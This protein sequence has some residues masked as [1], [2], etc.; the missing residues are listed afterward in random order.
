MRFQPAAAWIL[1]MSVALAQGTQGLPYNQELLEKLKDSNAM[2]RREA[3]LDLA[4]MGADAR[5]AVPDLQKAAVEADAGVRGASAYA[6]GEIGAAAEPASTTLLRN[7]TTDK[8]ANVRRECAVALGKIGPKALKT[9]PGLLT[10]LRQDSDG[11]VREAIAN[12]IVRV[13]SQAKEAWAGLAEALADPSPA[14]RDVAAR[15]LGK[16]GPP[17]RA[18]LPAVEKATKDSDAKVADA[19]RVAQLRINGELEDPPE[20]TELHQQSDLPEWKAF[21]IQDL[22]KLLKSPTPST[23]QKAIYQLTKRRAE[24]GADAKATQA[25]LLAIVRDDPETP[26]R[27]AAAL[28]VGTLGMEAPDLARALSDPDAV[29]RAAAARALGALGA[30][31]RGAARALAQ[32]RVRDVA[33]PV[34]RACGEAL[35][36]IERDAEAAAAGAHDPQQK[37]NAEA[38]QRKITD[39][40]VKALGEALDKSDEDVRTRA[41]MC[42]AELGP[43]AKD[44]IPQLVT[45]LK[46]N[47]VFVRAGAASALGEMGSDAKNAMAPLE[48]LLKDKDPRVRK[49]ATEAL[50]RLGKPVAAAAPAPKPN[51]P[52]PNDPKP[53]NPKPNDPPNGSPPTGQPTKP[54][55]PEPQPPKAEP[56]APRPPAG[57]LAAQVA[58]LLDGEGGITDPTS[59]VEGDAVSLTLQLAHDRFDEEMAHGDGVRLSLK[60]MMGIESLKE[61]SVIVQAHNG[62]V[63]RKYRVT[64]AKAAPFFDKLDDPY[65]RRR[66][67]EWWAEMAER[68]G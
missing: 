64:R 7:L 43:M 56:P 67:R 51:D 13:G 42:A 12:A 58:D 9:L 29:V 49:R 52:K 19:A 53:S 16:I 44:T 21:G 55:E 46:D 24:L 23:R 11:E 28:A 6:L 25:A 39:D 65:A 31:S 27:A 22:L 32:A 37:K 36:L 5:A 35:R 38:T 18:A 57:T 26:V 48:E 4:K 40:V 61:L 47:T 54:P 14:V 41:T 3:A 15:A 8:D 50:A 45:L 10:L 59:T 33:S 30:K 68:A 60:L 20:E 66:A 34:R 1:A 17:A 63:L 2:K 62:K